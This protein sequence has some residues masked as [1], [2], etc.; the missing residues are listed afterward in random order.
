MHHCYRAAETAEKGH[1]VRKSVLQRLQHHTKLQLHN[2][3]TESHTQIPPSSN[4]V[5]LPSWRII[6]AARQVN[7]TPDTKK[8][9]FDRN[10]QPLVGRG[11]TEGHSC[12]KCKFSTHKKNF[13]S[14]LMLNIWLFLC[15]AFLAPWIRMRWIV[16]Y[17]NMTGWS[18]WRLLTLTRDI[19]CGLWRKAAE[20]ACVEVLSGGGDS[21]NFSFLFLLCAFARHSSMCCCIRVCFMNCVHVWVCAA[22]RQR[23]GWRDEE[24]SGEQTDEQTAD[25]GEGGSERDTGLHERCHSGALLW[26]KHTFFRLIL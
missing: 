18:F 3:V 2:P 21:E 19:C 1:Y 11:N 14:C 10:P 22:A 12:V 24:V 13:L 7:I 15:V 9:P 25:N 4:A 16:K 17:E 8:V 6:A 26:L 5:T 20:S 23:R